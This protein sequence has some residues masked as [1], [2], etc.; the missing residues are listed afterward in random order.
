[1]ADW[2]KKLVKSISQKGGV[3]MF[4]RAQF[5]SQMASLTDFS[6]TILLATVF[7]VY[8]VLATFIGAVCGGVVNCIINYK[9]TFKSQDVKKKYIAIK[10]LSVWLGSIFLNTYGTYLVTEL[11]GK[12]TWL[13][14][15]LGEHFDNVF[16]LPKL[17]VSLLVGF[18]WNY[19]MQR[20]FVYKDRNF[21]KIFHKKHTLLSQIE[22]DNK[23]NKKIN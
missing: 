23:K 5:S 11:L 17:V 14:D 18:L 7:N 1:M 3:F 6:V 9:W 22:E 10:Y 12:F 8:Y 21:K 16:I 4:I 15:Y 19:N 20:L 2:I 13:R